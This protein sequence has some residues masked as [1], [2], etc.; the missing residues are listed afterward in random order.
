MV[1]SNFL[2]KRTVF[3][4][5]VAVILCCAG[6]FL[7]SYLPYDSKSPEPKILYIRNG[8]GLNVISS[9]LKQQDLV[10]SKH[11]FK[12]F[13]V[14]LG[15]RRSYKKGEYHISHNVSVMD[16]VELL[17]D[18]KTVLIPVTFPEGQRMNEMFSLLRNTSYQN[19]GKYEQLSHSIPFINSLN[20]KIESTILEGFLF[21]DTY[22]FSR[23]SSEKMILKTMV[24]NFFKKLPKDYEMLAANVGLSFYE[25]IILASIIEKETGASSERKLIS[26]VFH[27]RL[28]RH[29]RLQTDPTV[30]YGIKN[31]DG[32]L[33]RRQL[34]ADTPYNTYINFGLP[35]TPI[36]N[37]G[38]ASLEA[39]IHP[40]ETEYLFFVAKGDGTH[41]FSVSYEDHKSA[42]IKYQKRR[43]KQYRSF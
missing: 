40:S 34:R 32:N 27:N 37:P 18:G 13:S 2:N 28:E 22:K 36:A 5:L 6:L 21:P 4:S 1:L 33:T 8:D 26:S 39:A 14:L 41:E 35:P 42:V 16:L 11:F 31:F 17:S 19:K 12:W 15:K 10:R 20:Q 24:S 9:K 38:L 23:D 30:I 25:A 7:C 29:M 3:Y 43:N